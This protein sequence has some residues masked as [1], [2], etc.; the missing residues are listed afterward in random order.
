MVASLLRIGELVGESLEQSIL[1][2]LERSNLLLVLDNCEHIVD[3][4]AR[5]ADR[6]LRSC[7]AVHILTTSRELLRVHGE[8]AIPVPPL[9][10]AVELFVG[11][12]RGGGPG[13]DTDAAGRESVADV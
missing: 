7:D 2:Q 13:F 6:V 8:R 3:G 12:R 4:V 9:D 1:E 11:A 10:E 5:F